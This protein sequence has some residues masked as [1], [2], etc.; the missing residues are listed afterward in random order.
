MFGW[1]GMN[2]MTEYILPFEQCNKDN[3]PRV[4]G[5]CA[6][7]GAR[8]QAG[9]RVPPG[10][11]VT[12][13]AYHALLA[14]NRLREQ[15]HAELDVLVSSGDKALSEVSQKV[16]RLIEETPIS[17]EIETAIRKMSNGRLMPTCRRARSAVP[18]PRLARR[19]PLAGVA[20]NIAANKEE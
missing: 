17:T 14:S 7:L 20:A 19:Q 15:I 12:T 1:N 18:R 13:D 6:S 16:R 10:F 4:G 9:A 3:H 2:S 8:I 5:K 11:A